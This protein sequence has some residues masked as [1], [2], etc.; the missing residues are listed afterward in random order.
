MAPSFN[1]NTNRFAELQSYEPQ[2]E[3]E[4]PAVSK[5]QRQRA[6]AAKKKAQAGQSAENNN[7]DASSSK[8]GVPALPDKPKGWEATSSLREHEARKAREAIEVIRSLTHLSL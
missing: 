4:A 8:A 2:S 3:T 1:T 7:A 5:N 6:K